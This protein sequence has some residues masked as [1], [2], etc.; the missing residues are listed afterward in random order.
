MMG[1]PVIDLDTTI[2]GWY[3][4]CCGKKFAR[5]GEVPERWDEIASCTGLMPGWICPNEAWL[6]GKKR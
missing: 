3:C 2:T 1:I 6:V 5:R 4:F